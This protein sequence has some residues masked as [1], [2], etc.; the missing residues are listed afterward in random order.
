M[1][2][3]SFLDGAEHCRKLALSTEDPTVA[4]A[5]LELADEFE[6]ASLSERSDDG[7]E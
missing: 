3:E 5:Y 4:L 1:T 2:S 6:E 7:P